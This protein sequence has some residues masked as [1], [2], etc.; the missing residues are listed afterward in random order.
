[1]MRSV[2]EIIGY[3]LNAT[4]GEFGKCKDL[5][6]DDRWWTIRHMVASTG[7]WLIGRL[8]L[9]S[10]LMIQQPDWESRNIYLNVSRETI[11]NC[12]SPMEDETVSQ[13]HENKMAL[14]YGYPNYW[15][16]EGIWGPV[17]N[18]AVAE[19]METEKESED[20]KENPD[21]NH[22]RSFNEVKGYKIEAQDGTCGSVHD[23]ILD[24]DTW[25]LRHVIV[26]TGNLVN[27][28]KKIILPLDCVNRVS[29]SDRTL[30]VTL[31]KKDIHD[32]PEFRPDIPV[33]VELEERLY[34]F[35]GRPYRRDVRRTEP[36]N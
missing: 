4:D 13:E 25:A 30:G 26:D 6:F 17:P 31:E 29:W 36:A 11:E 14:Y 2:E 20:E 32:G 19:L 9:V 23:F 28:G 22:L 35:Y 1:M 7:P 3:E 5:L 34:D 33:N 24:D 15:A 21:Q 27:P 10:P 16:D 12:P 8:V 18:P